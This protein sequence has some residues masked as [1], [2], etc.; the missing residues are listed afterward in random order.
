MTYD[1][2][3]GDAAD[4]VV[5]EAAAAAAAGGTFSITADEG[6]MESHVVWMSAVTVFGNNK[7]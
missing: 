6:G 5:R 2:S 4:K 3:G 7:R 1:F